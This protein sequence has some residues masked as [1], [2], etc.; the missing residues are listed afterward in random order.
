ML[1]GRWGRLAWG[2]LLV[3]GGIAPLES[4]EW[5]LSCMINRYPGVRGRFVCLLCC[6]RRWGRE[7][8][9]MRNEKFGVV[10]RRALFSRLSHVVALSPFPAPRSISFESIRRLK[11]P[12]VPMFPAM[13]LPST[14]LPI[15]STLQTP[16]STRLKRLYPPLENAITI[17]LS[18]PFPSF[19]AKCSSKLRASKQ[20]A[21]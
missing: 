9:G 12:L 5:A 17:I 18:F 10:Q 7:D 8:G 15:P 2:V 20:E 3:V 11:T 6:G 13:Y 4:G 21:S 16:N 19:Y 14:H 1:G